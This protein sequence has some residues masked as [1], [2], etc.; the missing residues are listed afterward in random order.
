MHLL[1]IR[2]NKSVV[3]TGVEYTNSFKVFHRKNHPYSNLT[4]AVDSAASIYFHT[5]PSI[6]KPQVNVHIPTVKSPL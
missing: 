6:S 5:Y 2:F 3:P 1:L 4:M